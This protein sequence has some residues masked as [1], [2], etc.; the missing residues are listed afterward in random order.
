MRKKLLA[1]LMCATMVLGT[2]VTAFADTTQDTVNSIVGFT[3]ADNAKKGNPTKFI[4]KEVSANGVNG[5]I[6]DEVTFSYTKNGVLTSSTVTIGYDKNNNYKPVVLFVNK[7]GD[8]KSATLAPK[9]NATVLSSANNSV[10]A[11]AIADTAAGLVK[12]T[13]TGLDDEYWYVP[14][15]GDASKVVKAEYIDGTDYI[16]V[17]SGV[18]LLKGNSKILGDTVAEFGKVWAF[19]DYAPAADVSAM[20]PALYEAVKNGKVSDK[21]FAVNFKVYVQEQG[22]M[23][24]AKLAGTQAV[25]ADANGDITVHG[26]LDNFTT[27]AGGTFSLDYDLFTNSSLK[28]AKAIKISKFTGYNDTYSELFQQ[29]VNGFIDLGTSAIGGKVSFPNT[30]SLSG[31]FLFDIGAEADVADATTPAENAGTADK[32]DSSPKTGDVAPIAALA[33]VMMGAFGAMV[34][35]SKKRA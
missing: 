27:F 18:K 8:T 14:T 11:Q 28:D 29:A 32:A 12:V 2:S 17:D 19:V 16:K 21:A 35:A 31:T 7:D 4:A 22:Y 3:G 30:V 15:L 6:K 10:T 20:N 24:S 5:T 23:K 1:L 34:V 26:I 33:V 9:A 25:S 13:R